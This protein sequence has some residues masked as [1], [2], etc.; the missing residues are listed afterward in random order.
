MKRSWVAQIRL[1][2]WA[3]FLL[4]P[5]AG[6]DPAVP[7]GTTLIA[8]ARG[9][10]IA[11]VVLAFGYLLNSLADRHMDLDP[12]K[13][14]LLPRHGLSAQ[15]AAVGGL[16]VLA[17]VL[18]ASGPTTVVLATVTCLASGWAYSAGPRLKALPLLGSA[19][20]VGNFAPLLAV[21][22]AR[23][24]APPGLGA[25]AQWFALLLLQNQLLHE[26]ADAE[27]DARGGVHTTFLRL[28]RRGSAGLAGVCGLLLVAT[29]G[30]CELAV[31]GAWI[32]GVL[33]IPFVVA[34]PYLLSALGRSARSMRRVRLA[35]RGAALVTGALLYAWLRTG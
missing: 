17:F 20:N 29:V 31:G 22:L 13:R 27:E 28:G 32:A 25:L 30:A 19:L 18:A 26:A 33:A 15:R 14:D 1:R 5:L 10:A 12:D 23:D 11:F 21:G 24:D 3:H 2:H 35:H 34:F 6:I 7:P 16:V 9:I 4:L 8:L